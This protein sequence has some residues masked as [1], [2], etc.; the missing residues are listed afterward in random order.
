[1]LSYLHMFQGAQAAVLCAL[2]QANGLKESGLSCLY[3]TDVPTGLVQS[4]LLAKIKVRN[5][6]LSFYKYTNYTVKKSSESISYNK[7]L[8]LL[9]LGFFLKYF[10]NATK[11]DIIQNPFGPFSWLHGANGGLT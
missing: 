6:L 4:D 11:I 8:I 2:L 5:T 7:L 1:M 10:R 3:R 9:F